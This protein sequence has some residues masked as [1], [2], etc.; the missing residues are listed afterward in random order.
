MD[1]K[2]PSIQVSLFTKNPIKQPS[3]HNFVKS[4]GDNRKLGTKNLKAKNMI[5][6]NFLFVVILMATAFAVFKGA[7]IWQQE[8]KKPD[9]NADNEA[10]NIYWKNKIE[11]TTYQKIGDGDSTEA[12]LSYQIRDFST[13]NWEIAQDQQSANTL[14]VLCFDFQKNGRG[15]TQIASNLSVFSATDTKL[16]PHSLKARFNEKNA[17]K[18]TSLQANLVDF[19]YQFTDNSSKHYQLER[20]WLEDEIWTRLRQNPEQLP[21]GDFKM[22]PSLGNG[23]GQNL[24]PEEATAQIDTLISDSSFVGKNHKVYSLNFPKQKKTLA[25][26]YKNLP[27]FQIIGWKESTEKNGKILSTSFRQ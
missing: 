27:P 9:L 19:S 25:I 20:T 7:T 24:S 14:P 16:F 15:A 10:F 11:Q 13:Q 1:C 23:L 22:I 6:K 5:R 18:Q 21:T 12:V 4:Y 2:V 3:I 17:S 8:P 26:V